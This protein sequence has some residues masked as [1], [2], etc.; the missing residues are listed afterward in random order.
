MILNSV[1][2]TTRRTPLACLGSNFE[3]L[4]TNE[5]CDC[6]V[7][8]SCVSQSQAI[9]RLKGK[10]GLVFSAMPQRVWYITR[11]MV[12]TIGHVFV[13]FYKI[14]WRR[15]SCPFLT[16]CPFLTMKWFLWNGYVWKLP[17]PFKELLILSSHLQYSPE[18]S[19]YSSDWADLVFDHI[20]GCLGLP[21]KAPRLAQPTSRRAI[22]CQIIHP[23]WNPPPPPQPITSQI[24]LIWVLILGIIKVQR[25]A[26]PF[27]IN[28][29]D[30]A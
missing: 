4:K 2:V 1:E 17:L 29:L 12:Y 8:L 9:T 24:F 14:P 21:T 11:V 6:W 13:G 30:I 25:E 15:H 10:S 18:H 16:T 19:V 3:V 27:L 7:C 5:N 20:P 22:P 28:R 26:R 23:W